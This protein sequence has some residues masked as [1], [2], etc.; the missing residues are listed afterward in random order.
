MFKNSFNRKLFGIFGALLISLNCFAWPWDTGS[1]LRKKFFS[2]KEDTAPVKYVDPLL[3]FVHAEERVALDQFRGLISNISAEQRKDLWK[4]LKGKDAEPAG[5]IS[6]EELEKELRWASKHWITYR[7][8]KFDYHETVQYVAEK[9]GVYKAECSYATTFQLERRIMEKIFA[10]LWDKLSVEE[11]RQILA[12]SGLEPNNAAAYSTM[13]AAV[14]LGSLGATA[15]I[16]GFPFY[17]IVAKTVVVAAA[18]VFGASAATTITGVSILCGPIGWTVAGIAAVTSAILF[19]GPNVA[20]T[21]AFIVALHSIKAN[22]MQKS[23]IDIAPYV[24]M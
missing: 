22:A 8:A 20:K 4:A 10:E 5:E 13:T 24:L 3:P 9:L 14:L 23:G 16:A 7:F 21:A 18:A 6:A 2:K 11:R 1:W 19:G 12:E 15:V 17:I